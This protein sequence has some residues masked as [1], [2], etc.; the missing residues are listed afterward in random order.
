MSWS[1][2]ERARAAREVK[3]AGTDDLLDRVTAFRPGMEPAAAELIEEELARRGFDTGKMRD[4]TAAEAP[5]L[6][7]GPDGAALRCSLCRRPAVWQGWAW[8]RLWGLLLVFPRV[9]RYCRR[10]A[11]NKGVIKPSPL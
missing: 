7:R 6:L 9:F 3:A 1:A 10:H 4:Y 5:S 11:K 8:H 2:D